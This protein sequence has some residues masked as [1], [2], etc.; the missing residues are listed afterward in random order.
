[1]I[2]ALFVMS[3]AYGLL[4]LSV[5]LFA[6]RVIF[7]VPIPSYS[8]GPSIVKLKAADGTSISA[9]HLIN[10][11][12]K[13]T[14]LYSHG[15]AEDIGRIL[16]RLHALCGRGFSVFAYDY[17]GYG[18]SQ[19]KPNERTV[20]ADIDAA[21]DYLTTALRIPPERIIVYG[22]SVGA[23]PSVDLASRT[24][25]GGLVLESAFTSA[26]RVVTR[27]PL[28]PWDQFRS[29]DK[30]AMVKCPVF[31]IHGRKD[32]IV[33]FSHG[34][35]LFDAANEPKRYLWIDGAGHNDCLEIADEKYYIEL[36]SFAES[37]STG[38]P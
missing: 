18:T 25:A 12:A 2:I 1:M 28:L 8:D 3:G 35:E 11:S 15:N 7:P 20:I 16:P 29:I 22:R 38:S 36:K 27:V 24:R 14:I 32:R 26:F 37:L 17:H 4:W 10:L 5:W 30:I 34:Q 9:V 21:F 33:P 6:E 23:A 31:V 13:Y 19:G